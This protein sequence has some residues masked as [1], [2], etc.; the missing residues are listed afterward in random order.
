MK[1]VLFLEINGVV[2]SEDFFIKRDRTQP[3]V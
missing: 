1:K 2:N 3:L